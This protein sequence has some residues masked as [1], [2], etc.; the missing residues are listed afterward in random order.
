MKTQNAAVRE[1]V[2]YR[3]DFFQSARRLEFALR[4]REKM[5]EKGLRNQDVAERLGVSEANVSRWLRGNQNIGLDTMYQ[6]ADAIEVPLHVDF[7]ECFNVQKGQVEN[8]SSH[9][10][11]YREFVS[12]K[13]VKFDLAKWEGVTSDVVVQFDS[14][15]RVREERLKSPKVMASAVLLE[16]FDSHAAV[17]V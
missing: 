13:S 14:Y 4:V 3:V 6:L 17:F 10:E 12:T 16:G 1:A 9:A 7:G 11:T 15:R 5:K 8:S 2:K